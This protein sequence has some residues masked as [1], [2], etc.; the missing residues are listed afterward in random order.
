MIVFLLH[1]FMFSNLLMKLY[2]CILLYMF[3]V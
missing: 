3:K 1:L 2:V